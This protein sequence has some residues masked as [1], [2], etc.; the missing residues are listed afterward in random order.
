[1]TDRTFERAN[2]E[3]RARLARLVERLRPAQLTIDLGGGWT[4]AAALAHTGFW[5]R[6]QAERWT[7]ML[8]GTWSAVDASVFASENLAN[9][10]LDPYWSGIVPAGIPALA[11]DAATKVDALIARAPDS[12]VESQ[13]VPAPPLSPPRRPP[14]PD[15]A[16]PRGG[17][18]SCCHGVG[19]FVPGAQRGQ[20]DPARGADG[21]AL[22]GGSVTFVG[23]G[24]LDRRPA[25]RTSGLLGS[26]PG[27]SLALGPDIG[28]GSA[29]DVGP[30]C[31]RRAQRRLA[32]DLGSLRLCRPSLR[33]RRHNRRR[34]GDRRPDREPA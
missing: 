18:Q 3:S 12:M 9:A 31:G 33:Y 24:R 27:R 10:A 23:R 26:V 5:D 7:E 25:H 13:R 8:A 19:R 1:M 28:R 32:A 34:P 6:W 11:L 4:V 15:R 21:E 17:R 30:R 14:R 29:R 22:R 2:D 16:S 20:S